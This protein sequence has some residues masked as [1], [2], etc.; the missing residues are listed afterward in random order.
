MDLIIF[1]DQSFYTRKLS[2]LLTSTAER[3]VKLGVPACKGLIVVPHSPFP[4][5]AKVSDNHVHVYHYGH[6]LENHSNVA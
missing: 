2:T 1:E 6:T 4:T 5:T 3:H